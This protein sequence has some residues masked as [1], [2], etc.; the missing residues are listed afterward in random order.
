MK[1]PKWYILAQ[2]NQAFYESDEYD[3]AM[4]QMVE[5]YNNASGDKKEILAHQL[6]KWIAKKNT[7]EIML[8]QHRQE[9]TS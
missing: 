6:E 3:Q 5:E 7:N 8:K 9:V 1:E 4:N 2:K